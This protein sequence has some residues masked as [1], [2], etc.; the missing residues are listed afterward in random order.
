M[1]AFRSPAMAA[2]SQSLHPGVNVPG[3]PL[4]VQPAALA[5][6]SE[7]RSATA[8]GLPRT[9]PL[10]RMEPVA[11]PAPDSGNCS[12]GMP[13]LQ[14]R[15]VPRD[16]RQHRPGRYPA[17]LPDSPDFLSLPSVA[18]VSRFSTGS[19]FQVRYVSVGLLFLKP[20]GTFFTMP[21][22]AAC[23]NTRRDFAQGFSTI[24]ISLYFHGIAGI[25][26]WKH[27]CKNPGC[28]DLFYLSLR[29]IPLSVASHNSSPFPPKMARCALAR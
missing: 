27:L 13:P 22:K 1:T 26:V 28:E 6:R 21:R 24:F 19:S 29:I 4:R 16:Q 20:L 12:A 14:D 3:L 11:A 8:S 23:V 7:P 10:R 2:L 5:A 9:R 17:R 15:Y 25:R 18:S